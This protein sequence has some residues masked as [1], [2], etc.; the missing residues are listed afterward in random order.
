MGGFYGGRSWGGEV[1]EWVNRG[2][3]IW[4]CLMLGFNLTVKIFM[5]C[6]YVYW[7]IHSHGTPTPRDC[8]VLY[9]SVHFHPQILGRPSYSVFVG[10]GVYKYSPMLLFSV[11]K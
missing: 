4:A 2:G 1:G 9:T 7:V 10:M 8:I 5:Q 6:V 3:L 11:H